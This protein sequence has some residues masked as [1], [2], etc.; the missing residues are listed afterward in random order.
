MT[1]SAPPLQ[2]TPDQTAGLLLVARRMAEAHGLP[3]SSVDQ[4]LAATGASRE[5]ALEIE[6]MIVAALETLEQSLDLV[7][8]ASQVDDRGRINAL[9]HEAL[10]YVMQ[11]PDCTRRTSRGRHAANYR[12]FVIEL[13]TR[14]AD[15][16]ASAFADAVHVPGSTLEAWMRSRRG[17]AAWAAQAAPSPP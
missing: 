7:D 11:N 16:A 5:A 17:V 12:Q 2:P 14:Y 1:S 8:R 3:G 6:E 4:I 13:R 15:V 9:T 10:C